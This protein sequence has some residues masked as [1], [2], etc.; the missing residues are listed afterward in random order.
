MQQITKYKAKILNVL[1]EYNVKPHLLGYDYLAEA[2]LI[3]LEHPEYKRKIVKGVYFEIAQ[4]YNATVSKVERNIRTAIKSVENNN[5]SKNTNSYFICKIAEKI[6][7]DC[8][9][10]G[11]YKNGKKKK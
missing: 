4:M 11:N 7:C 10:K 8:L 2:I 6:K 5:D 1:Q 9:E 3:I